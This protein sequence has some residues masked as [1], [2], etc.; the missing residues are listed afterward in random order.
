MVVVSPL[1]TALSIAAIPHAHVHGIDG[2]RSAPGERMADE[3]LAQ[4]FGVDP[5]SP[6]P[7]IEASPA[8]TMRSLE[9]EVNGRRDAIGAEEGIGEFEESIGPR[10][11]A[12]VE[13]VTEGV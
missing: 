4:G 3:Q 13:G 5:S 2:R 11:E 1:G 6:E 12:L 8:A 9:A 7:S 10:V